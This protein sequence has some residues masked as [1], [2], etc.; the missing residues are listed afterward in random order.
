[1]FI[2][3]NG[4][5]DLAVISIEFYEKFCGQYELY[6]L[7][8]EAMEEEKNRDFMDYDDF[9]VDLKKERNK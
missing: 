8:D 2:T 5:G 1:M 4:H 7:P 9:M 3:K 6:H